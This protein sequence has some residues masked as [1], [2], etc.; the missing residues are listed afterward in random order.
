MVTLVFCQTEVRV[1]S[2]EGTISDF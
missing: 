1:G 2:G